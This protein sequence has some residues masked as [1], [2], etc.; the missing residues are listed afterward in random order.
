VNSAAK[1]AVPYFHS[2]QPSKDKYWIRNF[3]T[4]EIAVFEKFLQYLKK[5]KWQT[6]FLDEMYDLK[7]QGKRAK[8]KYCV[9]TFDDGYVDNFIYVYPLLKKY[10]MKGTIF[11]SPECIDEK[12]SKAKSMLEFED[13]KECKSIT[14]YLN[15]EEIIDMQKSGIMDIQSHTMTHTKYYSSD[16]IL[17]FH[18]PGDDCIYQITNIF[19]E[20]RAYYFDHPSFDKLLP[21]GTPFFEEKSAVV[22]RIHHI[23]SE[24][25][26]EIVKEIG[27]DIENGDYDFENLYKKVQPI[28]EV[29]RKKDTIFSSI[30][31]VEEYKKRLE[32]EIGGSRKILEEKLNKPVRFLCWP[33]GEN[34]EDVHQIALNNGYLAT[35]VGKSG[36]D[37]Y[38]VDRFERIGFSFKK[39]LFNSKLQW[40]IKMRSAVNLQPDLLLNKIYKKLRYS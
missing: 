30:E 25:N 26:Q 27:D 7:K 4:L 18:H 5:H 16:K 34:N 11:V 37:K 29:F 39:S 8:F 22:T 38:R 13:E 15:W 32:Y 24:F 17:S 10:G 40:Q 21:Y 28:I 6:I 1:I 36:A 35:T 14:G 2:I 23:N 33:H 3:L 20:L 12:R 19:P 9:L 31:S